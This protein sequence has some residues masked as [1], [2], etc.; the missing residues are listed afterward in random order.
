MTYE[1]RPAAFS[2][3]SSFPFAILSGREKNLVFLS[4]CQLTTCSKPTRPEKIFLWKVGYLLVY[5]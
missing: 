2:F 4:P 3:S 1:R 5:T